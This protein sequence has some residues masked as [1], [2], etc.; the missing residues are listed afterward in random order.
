MRQRNVWVMVSDEIVQKKFSGKAQTSL[1]AITV[2]FSSP[3]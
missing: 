1:A 3:S 2:A